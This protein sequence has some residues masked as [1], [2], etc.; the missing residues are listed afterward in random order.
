[1]KQTVSIGGVCVENDTPIE[2]LEGKRRIQEVEN[3]KCQLSLFEEKD[4][5]EVN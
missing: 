4:F 1:M 3:E 2:T 5:D